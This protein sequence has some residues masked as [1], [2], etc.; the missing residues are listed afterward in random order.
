[1]QLTGSFSAACSA[2]DLLLYLLA[3][4]GMNNDYLVIEFA[5]P[6]V[7]S[8]SM[9]ERM[10]LCNMAAELGCKTGLIA[11]DATTYAALQSAGVEILANDPNLHSDMYANYAKDILI[12]LSALTPMAA[13][14]HSPANVHSV[15]TLAGKRLDQCYLGACTGAKLEDLQMAARVL[16][17]HK[18][19]ASTRLLIAPASVQTTLAAS[20]DG[21]LTTLLDAGAILLPTGCGACAGL[22]AGLLAAGEVCIASTARNFKGRMGAPDSQVYLA[23]P[24]TVAASAIRGAIADPREFLGVA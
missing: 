9:Q 15:Q 17:G 1:V 8:L 24:Y 2:K 16:A 13:A 5:G 18:I 12:D 3:T 10:T 7:A 6:A 11:A 4:L 21:T 23:S 14:P 19:A 20:R 22:G